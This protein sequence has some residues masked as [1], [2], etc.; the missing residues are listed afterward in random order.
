MGTTLLATMRDEAPFILEWVAYHQAIGF[1][2][3]IVFSNDCIDGTDKV[4]SALETAGQVIHVPHK[5]VPEKL[6]AEQISQYVLEHDLIPDGDWV[7]WLD[8]DEFLNIREGQG[9]VNDLI[10]ATGSARG[11]CISWRVF[12]DAG[13]GSFSGSFIAEPFTSCAEPG[14]AWQ[15]VKTLFQMGP[16]VVELFQHKPILST[17][18]WKQGRTFLSSSGKTLSQ[19]S[20]YMKLW[21][22]GKKRGKIAT[23]EAGWDIAQINHYAV[24]TKRLFEYKK[25]RGR[26]GA[27]NKGGKARY[28]NAYYKG[29]NLNADTDTS[30]LRWS[31]TVAIAAKQLADLIRPSLDIQTLITEGYP[32]DTIQPPKLNEQSLNDL[33]ESSPD[34]RRYQRM[35]K[36]HY[37]E[38]DERKYSYSTLAA[39][40]MTAL[41]PESVIDVGC[42]IGLLNSYM[43]KGGANVLG[44]E[45]NWLEDGSMVLPPEH[46]QRVDLEEPF[47]LNQEFD[48]CCC[49]EVAEH[50]EPNRADGFVADLCDLSEVIVFSAAIGGQGGKG[51]KN[52]QWQEYWCNKFE[53][54]GYGTFDPFREAFRR[55]DK[56]LPWFKQNVLLFLKDGN[57]LCKSF[58]DDKITPECA[59]MI[60]PTYHQKILRRTRRR[61]RKKLMEAQLKASNV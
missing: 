5:P 57:P 55:D 19:K 2:R 40:V 25:A 41:R 51:H 22:Q 16:D 6:V 33:A 13:Q 27:A 9:T 35:H 52:E 36:D 7:I 12:G 8:A 17:T 1:E 23:D 38:I 15:N 4:L 60:L 47:S 34:T 32:E 54:N 46:Y 14:E 58:A 20:Q 18:F 43:A 39:T 56:M 42:G 3:I 21:S 45:G 37:D 10:A 59:N 44:L 26:I 29:L 49:I 53:Q 31:N 48:L 28:T 11:M 50:L 24:R 30:I 61:L